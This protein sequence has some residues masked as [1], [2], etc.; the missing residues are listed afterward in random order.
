MGEPIR[1]LTVDLTD[2]VIDML[3]ESD[4]Y[5]VIE[6]VALVKKLNLTISQRIEL[7]IVGQSLGTLEVVAKPLARYIDGDH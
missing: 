1:E 3:G 4:S 7:R 2:A 6:F 5:E